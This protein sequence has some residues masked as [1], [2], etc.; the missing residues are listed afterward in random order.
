M[1]VR[2]WIVSATYVTGGVDNKEELGR[3]EPP[4]RIVFNEIAA[5]RD[6]QVQNSIL[7]RTAGGFILSGNEHAI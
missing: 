4:K 5:A 1:T 3:E 2:S 7:P 6:Q